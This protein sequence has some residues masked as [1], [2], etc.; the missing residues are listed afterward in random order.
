MVSVIA[1]TTPTTHRANS[2]G[3]AGEAS[4]N[5]GQATVT[6][7][8][9]NVSSFLYDDMSYLTTMTNALGK[10]RQIV[11]NAAKQK[12]R[13]LQHRPPNQSWSPRAPSR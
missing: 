1:S 13:A 11:Y 2:A 9:G 6:D 5:G 7:A 8:L 3:D 10:S 12:D 4:R